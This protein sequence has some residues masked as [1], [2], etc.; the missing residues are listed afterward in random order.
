MA[1]LFGLAAALGWGA[2]DFCA[3]VAGMRLGVSRSMLFA[4]IPAFLLLTAWIGAGGAAIGVPDGPDWHAAPW[5][6]WAAG[7]LAA[8]INL[9]ATYALF[10]G[11]TTGL[12]GVVSPI[13]SSYGVATALLAALSGAAPGALAWAG[14]GTTVAGVALAAMPARSPPAVTAVTVA[15]LGRGVVWALLAAAGFGLGFW[16]QGAFAVPTLGAVLPVWLYYASGLPTLLVMT[17]GAWHLPARA[18]WPALA[19]GATSGVAAYVAFCA[20]LATGAIAIVTVLS[21]LASAVSV[22][23]ARAFLGER[24]SRVQWGGVALILTG[25]VVLNAGR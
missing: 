10:R 14:I 5:T 13:A 16:L 1:V 11:L 15:P 19:G 24:L 17:R 21:S 22:L 3:R 20:G 18:H 2:T 9:A 25:L 6:A 4:Q 8:Q 7:L 12:V 23:L